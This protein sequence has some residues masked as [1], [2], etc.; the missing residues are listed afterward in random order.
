MLKVFLRFNVFQVTNAVFSKFIFG[1]LPKNQVGVLKGRLK[2]FFEPSLKNGGANR[3]PHLRY[4]GH[5]RLPWSL[6]NNPP[7]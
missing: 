7:K 3:K 1:T 4:V 5:I 6:R 2:G